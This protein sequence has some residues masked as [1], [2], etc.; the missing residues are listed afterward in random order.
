MFTGALAALCYLTDYSS[1]IYTIP[2]ALIWGGDGKR[3]NKRTVSQFALGFV[4]VALP[5]WIRNVR[6]TGNPFFTLQWLDFTM[7]SAEFP[8]FSLLRDIEKGHAMSWSLYVPDP[9]SFC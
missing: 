6:L 1:L 3:W 7:R 2:L 5:W 9:K 8:G 4:I